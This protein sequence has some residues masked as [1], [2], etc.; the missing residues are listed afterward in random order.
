MI[1]ILNELLV[2][3]ASDKIRNINYFQILLIFLDKVDNM[4][5][6]S[7]VRTTKRLRSSAEIIDEVS[8]CVVTPPAKTKRKWHSQSCGR[9]SLSHFSCMRRVNGVP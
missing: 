9:S 5:Y 6:K 7:I 8:Q 4:C 1:I 2:S 3:I